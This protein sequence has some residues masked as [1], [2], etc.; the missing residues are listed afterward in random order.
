MCDNLNKFQQLEKETLFKRNCVD[1]TRILEV[2]VDSIKQYRDKTQCLKFKEDF[3]NSCLKL[4]D[5]IKQIQIQIQERE[6]L[7][8]LLEQS[9]IFYDAQYKDAKL[10]VNVSFKDFEIIHLRLSIHVLLIMF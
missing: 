2:T 9:E 7:I 1:S 10:V 8:K 4:D 5:Y 6:Q 3:Q